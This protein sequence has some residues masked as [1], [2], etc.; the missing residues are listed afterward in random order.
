MTEINDPI[1]EHVT[2]LEE[3]ERAS[4]KGSSLISLIVPAAIIV[5]VLSYTAYAKLDHQFRELSSELK[6]SSKQ[7]NKDILLRAA[8]RQL[9]QDET[10]IQRLTHKLTTRNEENRLLSEVNIKL[11]S[12]IRQLLDAKKRSAKH[13][14]R[15]EE[16]LK[17]RT[18]EITEL[19]H[20]TNQ[21]HNDVIKTH[22]VLIAIQR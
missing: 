13:I 21:S 6:Q 18:E 7:V 4:N 10:L 17:Q 1:D 5:S 19:Q 15:L 20:E 11:N 16:T 14:D 8:T 12:S 2:R 3:H 22:N 9:E